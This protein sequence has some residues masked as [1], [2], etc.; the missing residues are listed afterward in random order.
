MSAI[1]LVAGRIERTR[2]LG[3][4]LAAMPARADISTA[5]VRDLA[6]V[7]IGAAH[8]GWESV[9]PSATAGPI[10]VV[11]DATLYYRNDLVRRAGLSGTADP[12]ASAATLIAEAWRARKAEALALLEGD[13]A[14]V[15]WDAN[16]NE[17]VAARDFSGGRPLFW[18]D[19]GGVLR[20]ASTIGAILADPAVPRDIDFAT[21]ASVAAGIWTH[22]PASS[23]IAITELPAGHVLT[24]RPGSAPVV[25]SFWRPPDTMAS[26]R[27][28]L[29]PAAAELRALLTD[30]VRE[31]LAP[32]GTTAV[33]LSG[34]WDSTAV[35]G[36]AQSVVRGDDTRRVHGVSISYPVGDPGREDE[37]IGEVTGFWGASPDLIDV[38]TIPLLLDAEANAAARTHPFAHTY[39]QWNRALSRRAR[40][41]DARVI[42]DGFG[43]DQLFQ[44]SGV[45]LA[46]LFRSGQWLELAGQ[47][48]Q[49]VTAGMTR[50]ERF[51]AIVQPALPPRLQRLVATNGVPPQHYLDRDVPIWFQEPF[52]DAHRVGARDAAARPTLPQGNL[53][54]AE[55]HA[56]LR[57]AFFARIR[58]L[59]YGFGIQ[60]GVEIRSPLL[61]ARVVEFAARRSWSDRADGRETKRL[62]RHAVRELLPASVLAPRS[63]RTGTTNAYFLR[64]IRRSAEL[65]ERVLPA[66]RLAE[67]GMIDPAILRRAWEHLQEHDD[68]ELAG[69]VFFTLQAELWMR[70][71]HH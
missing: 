2:M 5:A 54:L 21:V 15:L 71:Q 67:I 33:S 6:V 18:C 20:V 47:L 39:E 63:H 61:D 9:H 49:G 11:A 44:V 52:L 70:G 46:E 29:E 25:R 60:E 48:R 23:Y 19:H 1:A 50:R 24:W 53:V 8:F 13:F 57:F 65:I 35:Y 40:A 14:F 62:L 36:I 17:V 7:S 32:S 30:A 37:F 69:R 38:D 28:P 12:D 10:S 27:Q 41:A 4:M 26:R 55:S 68:D 45:Y 66:M 59:L 34:G 42:L 22:P 3:E 64:Q 16:A 51:D 43:G 58:S 31:R 56:F